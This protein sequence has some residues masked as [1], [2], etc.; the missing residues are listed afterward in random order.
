MNASFDLQTLSESAIAAGQGSEEKMNEPV[1]LELVAQLCDT[2]ASHRIEYCHWK[3]NT[4]LCRSARGE[5][6]LDLLVSRTH[7]IRFIEILCNLGFRE[8]LAPGEAELPGVRN[9][10]GYDRETGRLVHVHA[11]FHLILGNDLSKNYRLPMEQAFLESSTQGSLFRV[12]APEFEFV[13]LV[14]RMVLKHSTWDALLMRHGR[15][16]HS[17]RSELDD[18]SRKVTLSDVEAVFPH[19]PGLNR[20]LFD[21]CVQSLQPGCPFWQRV[22]AGG[23]LQE[24]LQTCA[25]RPHWLDV[26]LKFTRRVWQP[27]LKRGFGYEPK[28][29]FASGGL[30]IA[31]VGGD[32]SGKTTVIDEVYQWLSGVFEVRKFHM[33]KPAWSWTTVIIRGTLKMGTLLGL[34]RF[35]G[36][37]HE[38]ALQPHGYPWFIRAVC[39][40]CDR[41]LTYIQARRFSSNGGLVLCDR[42]SFPGFMNM[43]GAQCESATKKLQNPTW[44]HKLLA[45]RENFYYQQIKSPDLII[46]LKVAPDVAVQRKKDETE[47]SVRARSTEVWEL[48]WQS[49]SASVVAAENPK[50]EVLSRV[51]ALVWG[52]L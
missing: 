50:E 14:I 11:H 42:Y 38:E 49:M 30:F 36:D 23:Q 6:D 17:E 27:I 21:L 48:D 32:G 22:R 2:L 28:N 24:A 1:T 41:Y 5:N 39:T 45:G 51:K 46:V 40:A 4:F 47:L 15:L 8:I 7:A 33:G 35:E 25:R 16:S 12:P 44:F 10:Y 52:H 3:S 34:Y 13:V 37:T 9:Y 43:D 26:G 19:L 20:D 29:R 18:L 31:I